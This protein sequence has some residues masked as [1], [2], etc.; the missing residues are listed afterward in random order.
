MNYDPN[1]RLFIGF[2]NKEVHFNVIEQY[3]GRIRMKETLSWSTISQMVD[4]MFTGEYG[5]LQRKEVDFF[6]NDGVCLFKYFV[7][8]DD[9][10]HLFV[11][12]ILSLNFVC[13]IMITIS[14]IAINL[15]S[16]KSSSQLTQGSGNK[17]ITDRNKT[18]QRKISIIIATDF[19]CWVP[20]VIIC[21]LHTLEV[22]DATPW[23]A[24]FSIVILPINSVINPLLYDGTITN[25]ISKYYKTAINRMQP[26]LTRITFSLGFNA[27]DEE[28]PFINRIKRR[29]HLCVS[30]IKSLFSTNVEENTSHAFEIDNSNNINTGSGSGNEEIEMVVIPKKKIYVEDGEQPCCS[31]DPEEARQAV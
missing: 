31:K 1:I 20:F 23:Y 12:F 7:K 13:F 21:S 30:G 29:L 28:D 9:P 25:T 15:M 11:W 26:H 2:P 4:G 3:Y 10:Q 6:G 16:T 5:N 19:L 27:S 18:M 17:M 24:L 8:T 14:Y 22:L